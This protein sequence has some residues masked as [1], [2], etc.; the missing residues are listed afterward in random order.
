M[1]MLL[2]AGLPWSIA[3]VFNLRSPFTR[4]KTRR[5]KKEK[6]SERERE[7]EQQ[8]G[9]HQKGPA[10]LSRKLVTKRI[11]AKRPCVSSARFA[12]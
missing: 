4:K 9:G 8:K 1:T 5:F 11:A 10:K 6:V 2:A 12:V 3:A 7:R